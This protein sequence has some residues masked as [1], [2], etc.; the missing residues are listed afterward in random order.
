MIKL[1]K[2][3]VLDPA[4]LDF[5]AYDGAVEAYAG[6]R[7]HRPRV[8]E[9]LR[10]L[11]ARSPAHGMSMLRLWL[12]KIDAGDWL[13]GEEYAPPEYVDEQGK[14]ELRPSDLV[15]ASGATK[16]GGYRRCS[17]CN[18]TGWHHF[19]YANGVTTAARCR[20]CSREYGFWLAEQER[21]KRESGKSA[22]AREDW[23]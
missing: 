12:A 11:R 5:A 7:P 17:E 19:E 16:R 14:R 10:R 20:E 3:K 18:G 1:G 6:A 21:K 8:V 23:G 4:P 22:A 15:L 9:A 2:V 13:A